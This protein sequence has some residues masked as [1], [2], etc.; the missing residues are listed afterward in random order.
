MTRF[1]RGMTVLDRRKLREEL[2]QREVE[3][4]YRRAFTRHVSPSCVNAMDVTGSEPAT[5]RSLHAACW[6]EHPNSVGCL[7][8]CHDEDRGGVESGGANAPFA[9]GQP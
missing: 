4:A 8:P 9:S 1:R 3:R 6:G 2:L 5:A 7:C